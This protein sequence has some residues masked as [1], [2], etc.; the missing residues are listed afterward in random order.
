MELAVVNKPL[1][2]LRT[3]AET[4]MMASIREFTKP[5][6]TDKTVLVRMNLTCASNGC[7]SLPFE[8]N[9]IRFQWLMR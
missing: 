4:L 3:R 6:D 5:P 2:A 8:M 1:Q 9:R 7:L